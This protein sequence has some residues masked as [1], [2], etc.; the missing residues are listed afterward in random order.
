MIRVS[1][2]LWLSVSLSL[3]GSGKFTAKD[4]SL[5]GRRRKFPPKID[6]SVLDLCNMQLK[7]SSKWHFEINCN[8]NVNFRV[9]N[10]TLLRQY[11]S[12]LMQDLQGQRKYRKMCT[13][14]FILPK[15]LLSP[16]PALQ[17]WSISRNLC[18]V[19]GHE[20]VY[21]STF[22]LLLSF[23]VRQYIFCWVGWFIKIL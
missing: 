19:H 5:F 2:R 13:G 22:M 14:L 15:T 23:P 4:L 9:F 16:S 11:Q 20:D 1:A 6:P 7:A 18:W 8:A 17:L 12:I 21:S 10:E 3:Q